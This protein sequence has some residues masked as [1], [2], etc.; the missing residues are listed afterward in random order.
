[1]VNHLEIEEM[2][3]QSLYS[4]LLKS[5][6]LEYCI[7]QLN[8]NASPYQFLE[9]HEIVEEFLHKKVSKTKRNFITTTIDGNY[10]LVIGVKQL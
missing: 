2:Q 5:Y 9:I 8:L 3:Y 6:D 4:E 1:M 7:S 10:H